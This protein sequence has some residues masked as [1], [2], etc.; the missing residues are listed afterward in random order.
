MEEKRWKTMQQVQEDIARYREMFT[1]VRL[2]DGQTLQEETAAKE[3][4][5]QARG[6]SICPDC[7]DGCKNCIAEKA[8]REKAKKTKLE[9]MND[10]MFQ[11]TAS[12]LEI[13][14]K[15]YVL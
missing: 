13:E 12:Y 5:K 14:G 6:E 3:A 7:R 8:L 9:Y 1:Q 2:L 10:D 15:P 11:I 4:E